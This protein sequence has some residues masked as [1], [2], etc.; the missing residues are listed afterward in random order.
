M[1]RVPTSASRRAGLRGRARRLTLG[2]LATVGLAPAVLGAV[3]TTSSAA[4]TGGC[5]G[6]TATWKG[7]S[8]SVIWS[9]ASNWTTG[10]VPGSTNPV[11]IPG[12]TPLVVLITGAAHACSVAVGAAAPSP[13]SVG[14][15]LELTGSSTSLTVANGVDDNGMIG[16]GPSTQ[17]SAASVTI[18]TGAGL[19]GTGTITGAV[20]NQGTVEALPPSGAGGP[21]VLTVN[22]NYVQG[23]TGALD[24]PIGGTV[25]SGQ[26]GTLRVSGAAQLAGVLD[27][28][29]VTNPPTAFRPVA[30]D[31]Y[32]VLTAAALAG[33]FSALTDNQYPLGSTTPAF[34]YTPGYTSTAVHDVVA[35][36]GSGTPPPA[37][38]LTTSPAS[39]NPGQ[40]VTA[41]W[42]G[43]A[44]SGNDWISMHPAGAPDSNYLTFQTISTASDHLAFTAPA[45]A[46][47]YDFR[48]FR[49]GAKTAT[50]G[51]F[52]VASVVVLAGTSAGTLPDGATVPAG[53]SMSATWN[54][55]VPSGNDWIS[56]H[57]AGA[58]DSTY[59]TFQK[60]TGSEG[61]VGFTAPAAAGPYNFRL[62][63]NG[64][65]VATSPT[66]NV[67]PATVDTEAASSLVEAAAPGAFFGPTA[68]VPADRSTQAG[69]LVALRQG[70][71]PVVG[72]RV[73]LF[74]SSPT[75]R[76][77]P[78]P[79]YVSKGQVYT[80][81]NG[82][83]R[84]FATDS[85]LETATFWA[86][87]LSHR[88][89]VGSTAQVTFGCA[90][91]AESTV[92]VDK[93][94][95]L[96]DGKQKATVTVTVD[97][98]R[99]A[100]SGWSIPD[101]GH[102]V[103]LSG[104]GA[105]AAVAPAPGSNTDGQGDVV[106]DHNGRA[107]FVMT[108]TSPEAVDFLATDITDP[109]WV[110]LDQQATV[111]F[112]QRMY[113][114][115]YVALGDSYSAGVGN[116]QYGWG[117]ERNKC[118]RSHKA[119][120]PLIDKDQKLNMAFVACTGA[121]T[122]DLFTPN[123]E[124]NH[125]PSG[126]LE[127]AQM[128]GA[129]D[130]T[131]C[132]A[133]KDPWLGPLTKVVTLTIGGNDVGFSDVLA[134]CIDAQTSFVHIEGGSCLDDQSLVDQ[135]YARISALAGSGTA[136][137]PEGQP[138]HPLS[139]VLADIHAA[140]PNAT[141]YVGLYPAL[142]APVNNQWFQGDCTVGT[143]QVSHVPLVG[144]VVKTVQ[145]DATISAAHASE[146]Y[147]VGTDADT[148][149]AAVTRQMGPWARV[150][151][152]PSKFAGHALCQHGT[153]LQD[154]NR[155]SWFFALSSK[156][157]YNDQSHPQPVPWSFHPNAAGQSSGFKA[158]FEGAGA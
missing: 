14:V 75:V 91:A 65:K 8:S 20:D 59:L 148:T 135:V 105:T 64:L 36:T 27:T 87:D 95:V 121:V 34:T 41:T 55:L 144:G 63:S 26:Y 51:S 94:S 1:N 29:S 134:Q 54:G 155:S 136:T 43:L 69:I 140:A 111:I 99:D 114:M 108:D 130:A 16:L 151:D 113:G 123:N 129:P 112:T 106:T 37:V 61:S 76:V 88:V 118:Y 92:T 62:F 101:G 80:D 35:A 72:A 97:C 100:A 104:D 109:T 147:Q 82:F 5:S 137:S 67:V 66:F 125:T 150:V 93:A 142:F 145:M 70:S 45:T 78:D 23:A 3:A 77:S 25:A 141:V 46:G 74:D 158:A 89:N 143:L 132:P 40:T 10:S 120:G 2:A 19:T 126:S 33:T 52:T 4:V 85:V 119:Y 103:M 11:V 18:E 83:V 49:N 156:V 138:I 9:D 47:S 21:F 146:I 28:P 116:G 157:D 56:M 6:A 115:P 98:A 71:T 42:F 44:P 17:L 90:K 122:N 110:P 152:A 48:L 39:V 139:Q 153:S 149:I 131:A 128:C 107:R 73:E 22:G 127:P 68:S 124:D 7:T 57:P 102:T 117:S 38:G 24:A 53:S 12:G 86:R 60:I 15:E 30:G 13:A 96:A 32:P 133:G 50:S 81:A 58:P 31:S 79:T 154:N 84:Y